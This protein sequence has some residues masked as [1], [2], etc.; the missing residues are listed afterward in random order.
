L[1][2]QKTGYFSQALDHRVVERRHHLLQQL[3]REK[4]VERGEAELSN[5]WLRVLPKFCFLS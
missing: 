1:W 3:D 2:F 5:K 4:N